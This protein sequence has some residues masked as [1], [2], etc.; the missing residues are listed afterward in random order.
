VCNA[1]SEQWCCQNGIDCARSARCAE[2]MQKL[3]EC[4]YDVMCIAQVQEEYGDSGTTEF[5]TCVLNQ[6]TTQCLPGPHCAQLARCCREINQTSQLAAW[7]VC[8]GAVN[9]LDETKCVTILDGV[10][11]PQLGP[12]FC[13]GAAPPASDGGHD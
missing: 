3:L 4:V 10:L 1:C 11:R 8:V 2:G 13:G 5:Q 9:A 7:Q 12:T 6:C